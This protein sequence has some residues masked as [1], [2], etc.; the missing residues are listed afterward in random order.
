MSSNKFRWN[1]DLKK[2]AIVGIGIAIAL[3]IIFG[4]V[5]MDGIQKVPTD[6][7]ITPPPTPGKLIKLNLTEGIGFAENP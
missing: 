6:K 1:I 2:A 7:E 5:F 4:A 3:V